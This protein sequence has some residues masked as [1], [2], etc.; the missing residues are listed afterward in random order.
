MSEVKNQHYISQ[1]ILEKFANEKNQVAEALVNKKK[2]YLTNYR[3]SMSE[4]YTYEHPELEVNEL[5][6][7]FSKIEGY[8]SPALNYI[9]ELIDDFENEQSSFEL[10][11]NQIDKYMKEFI[12]FYYRSGALLH[13]FSFNM[14]DKKHRIFLLLDSIMNSNYIE[15]LSQAIINYYDFFLIKSDESAF[16]LSDQY[17]SS[18]SLNVK[19]RFLNISNRNLGLKD[20]IILIPLSSKYYVAYSNGKTPEYLYKGKI[21]VLTENQVNKVNKCII[22]NSYIKCIG[23][24]IA[25]VNK[26]LETFEF[27]SPV[28]SIG[29]YDNGDSASSTIKKEIFFYDTDKELWEFFVS[30]KYTKFIK[31]EIGRNDR[32]LCNS[33]K[34]FKNCCQD[35]FNQIMEVLDNMRYKRFNKFKIKPSLTIEKGINELYIENVK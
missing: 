34:K 15:K 5:E 33:G 3:Q 14:S 29:I 1:R 31:N 24:K 26:Y 7:F 2:V 4:T 19:G 32:C 8:F 20:I 25:L 10:I 9:L 22:N 16:L 13:E 28:G 23:E 30:L 27:Q 11:K 6:T 21:N 35:K 17:I 18:A 12:I